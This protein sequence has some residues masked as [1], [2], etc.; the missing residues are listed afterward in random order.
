[1]VVM[2]ESCPTKGGNEPST[3]NNEVGAD[4]DSPFDVSVIDSSEVKKVQDES[5]YSHQR[6]Y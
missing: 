6:A 2:I 5:E 4:F 3:V 1:M